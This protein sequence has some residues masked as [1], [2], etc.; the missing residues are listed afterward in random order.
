MHTPNIMVVIPV[1]NFEIKDGLKAENFEFRVG[2]FA[3]EKSAHA[4]EK[5]FVVAN[6]RDWTK[7]AYGRKPDTT[8]SR[9][10]LDALG[11]EYYGSVVNPP[12][13]KL[14]ATNKIEIQLGKRRLKSSSSQDEW[15]ID[16]RTVAPLTLAL[17]LDVYLLPLCK[18]G[19][20]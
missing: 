14:P 6:T 4:W 18:R 12:K 13:E 2:P 20:N 10:I 15:D 16:Y 5:E 17:D 19:L 11:W 8:E 9:G 3:D 7:Y 1:I